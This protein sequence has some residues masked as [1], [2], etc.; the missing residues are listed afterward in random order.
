MGHDLIMILWFCSKFCF[1]Q[2]Q[3]SEISSWTFSDVVVRKKGTFYDFL[4]CVKHCGSLD[5]IILKDHAIKLGL[6]TCWVVIFCLCDKF[7]SSVNKRNFNVQRGV[8]SIFSCWEVKAFMTLL[9]YDRLEQIYQALK[10]Y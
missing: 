10:N 4:S 2:Y 7:Q 8:F 9:T 6:Y 1:D 3:N 5:L